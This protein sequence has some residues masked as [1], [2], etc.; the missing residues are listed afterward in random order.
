MA[1]SNI[2]KGDSVVVIGLGRFGTS[3]ARSLVAS[4]HEVLAIDAREEVVQ[5]LAHELPHVVKADSTE[6]KALQQLSVA[7]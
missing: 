4:G 5:D 3:V 6:L 2:Q 1:E 7:D